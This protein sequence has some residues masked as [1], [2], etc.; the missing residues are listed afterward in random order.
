MKEKSSKI[1]SVADTLI[2]DKLPEVALKN[3]TSKKSK[4][5]R[6]FND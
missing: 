3:E 6:Y 5:K 1:K 2:E 4:L